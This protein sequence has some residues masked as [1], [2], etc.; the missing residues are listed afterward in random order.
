MITDPSLIA[1]YFY[2]PHGN[3]SQ[4]FNRIIDKLSLTKL[5]EEKGYLKYG[6]GGSSVEFLV[7]YDLEVI[8]IVFNKE[9][10]LP[11]TVWIDQRELLTRTRD[12]DLD[13]EMFIGASIIYKGLIAQLD[14]GKQLSEIENCLKNIS[15]KRFNKTKY[16][17]LWQIGELQKNTIEYVFLLAK[18][19]KTKADEE[20]IFARDRGIIKID[21]HLHKANSQIT[22]YADA[23]EKMMK[24]AKDLDKEQLRLVKSLCKSDIIEQKKG[25]DTISKKYADLVEMTSW[26]GII[27]NTVNINLVDYRGRWNQIQGNENMLSNFQI[28][29]IERDLEQMQWD[30]NY[31]NS[32]MS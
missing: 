23:R 19:V 2:K 5:Q 31:Y 12:S 4:V 24:F 10:D 6:K 11:S 27:Q 18:S 7:F 32:I 28:N 26:A 14:E 21:S 13:N 25:L 30:F 29:R 17:W 20:F 16:G 8:R 3:C 15:I 1:V 22:Y 9:G